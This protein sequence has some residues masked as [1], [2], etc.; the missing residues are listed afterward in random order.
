MHYLYCKKAKQMQYYVD[1]AKLKNLQVQSIFVIK[2]CK[3]RL[4]LFTFQFFKSS[5]FMIL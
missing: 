4:I 1:E 3:W 2:S 5:R